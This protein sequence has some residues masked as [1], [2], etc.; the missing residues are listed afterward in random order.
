MNGFAARAVADVAGLVFHACVSVV[1]EV[2][3]HFGFK[4]AFDE[5][6]GDLLENAVLA[7]EVFGRLVGLE[8]LV[9]EFR[10]NAGRAGRLGHACLLVSGSA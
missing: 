10:V 1:T 2:V 8:E 3:G 9:D 5:G 6:F 7:G 4:R